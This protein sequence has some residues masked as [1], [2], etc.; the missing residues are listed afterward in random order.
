LAGGEILN[1]LFERGA[2]KTED[3]GGGAGDLWGRAAVWRITAGALNF[4]V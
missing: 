4:F 2:V 3:G 1:Q